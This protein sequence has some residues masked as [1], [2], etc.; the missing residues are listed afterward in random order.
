MELIIGRNCI[1]LLYIAKSKDKT[2]GFSRESLFIPGRL[3]IVLGKG[4]RGGGG[5][6]GGG[7][8]ICD[9]RKLQYR[10]LP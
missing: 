6:G 3:I 2:M 5:G 9:L 10:K 4:A 8:G 1:V 7:A